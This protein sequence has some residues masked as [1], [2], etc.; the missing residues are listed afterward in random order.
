M[1]TTQAGDK[2]NE[3]NSMTDKEIS[4]KLQKLEIEIAELREQQNQIDV[5][6]GAQWR[7]IV[8][9]LRAT[10][11]AG[12]Q[13]DIYQVCAFISKR[14]ENETINDN[15]DEKITRK[16]KYFYYGKAVCCCLFQTVVLVIFIYDLIA[17]KVKTNS[18]CRISGIELLRVKIVAIVAA[19]YISFMIGGTMKN[20]DHQGL[21][22]IRAKT[23]EDCP[24]FINARWVYMGLYSNF[25]ALFIAF[26]GSYLVIYFS[27]T[28]FDIVFNCV[29][30]FF[31]LEIDDFLVDHWDYDFINQ[32]LKEYHEGYD[33][34]DYDD[35][36]YKQGAKERCCAK[37]V[38][39]V[40]Q[41]MVWVSVF[42]AI[43][44]PIWI[45][46]CF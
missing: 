8:N 3:N 30:I 41:C 12:E 39:F 6:E 11:E 34:D 24:P 26:Y 37:S 23:F 13:L 25:M 2:S 33:E 46:V 16:K 42:V 9:K 15:P 18:F 43:V 7:D 22:E 31:A 36:A 21:Y 17:E 40:A 20:L 29:A 19:A 1:S 5:D 44:A 35:L 28:S 32:W 27:E 45:T 14:N 10:A 38:F 4:E